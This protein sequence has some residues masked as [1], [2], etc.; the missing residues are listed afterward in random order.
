MRWFLAP[1]V[2]LL[3]LPV[4]AQDANQAPKPADLRTVLL[5]GL[6]ET[7]NHK[8]WFVSAKDATAGLTAEQSNWTQGKGNHSV[9]QLVYHLVYW[10]SEVLGQLKGEPGKKFDG[11][12]DA[13]FTNYDSKQWEATLTKYDEVMTEIEKIVESADQA[14]LE[15]MSATIARVGEHNA[16]HIGEMVVIRKLQ[17]SWNPDQG[18][19]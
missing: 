17:G 15:K 16:Y 12:N 18:V 19:K 5:Q 14:K 9:G 8:N 1:A 13:T 10:N 7:H 3:A 2:L 4:I 6:H 11:N